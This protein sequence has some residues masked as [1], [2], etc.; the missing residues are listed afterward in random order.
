M[1]YLEIS[2]LCMHS[3]NDLYF[4]CGHF[5]LSSLMFLR[6]RPVG[7]I[8]CAIHSLSFASSSLSHLPLLGCF[9]LFF[10]GMNYELMFRWNMSAIDALTG[11][12]PKEPKDVN[13]GMNGFAASVWHE[14]RLHELLQLV[15]FYVKRGMFHLKWHKYLLPAVFHTFVQKAC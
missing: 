14:H 6:L 7:W 1:V 12:I 13:I 15:S 10:G 9:W 5:E 3:T 4:L 8:P 11:L 2:L